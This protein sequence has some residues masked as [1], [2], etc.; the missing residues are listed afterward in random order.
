MTESDTRGEGDQ[1][2]VW[3]GTTY[4]G[5]SWMHTIEY[6]Y[7]RETIPNPRYEI[8]AYTYGTPTVYDWEQDSTLRIGKYTS[9][10]DNVTILLGGNHRTDWV[11]TY[12][13]PSLKAAWPTAAGIEGDQTTKGDVVIGNDVWVAHGVTIL[14]GVI[15]GDGAV[16]A[17]GA[18]VVEDVEPYAIV[19]GNPAKR[20]KRRFKK[21]EID[22]LLK[23]RWWDWPDEKV[24]R[25]VEILCSGDVPKIRQVSKHA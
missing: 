11:S 20:V 15:I 18:V 25:H 24:A 8:G 10:A 14:S 22:T 9:I 1:K 3:D 19:A 12:P 21:E 5:E 17:A 16:V 7:T 2:N 23:A 13:F 6:F 4:R